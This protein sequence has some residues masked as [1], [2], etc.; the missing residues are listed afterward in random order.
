MNYNIACL[1]IFMRRRVY[2]KDRFELG[3]KLVNAREEMN[4]KQTDVCKK[5][6]ISQ[7]DLSKIE[8]GQKKLDFLFLLELTKL[9]K[10]TLEYFIP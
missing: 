10:K 7:S 9:Y 1:L 2:S 8:N 5:L 4:L 6:G 3:A